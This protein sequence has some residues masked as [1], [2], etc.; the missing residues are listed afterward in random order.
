MKIAIVGAGVSGLTAAYILSREHTVTLYESQERLGGHAHTVKVPGG[1]GDYWVDTGFLVYN[2]NTYP[3]FIELMR[4]LDIPTKPTV[5]SFSYRN[6]STGLEWKGSNLNTVFGQRR[7]ILRPRF[8]RMVL[9]ILAFNR[10][11]RETLAGPADSGETL[12]QLLAKKGWSQ[13]FRDWYLRPMGASIWSANPEKFTNMP[14]RSFAEFFSRHGLLQVK[15]QPKWRTIDGGSRLYVE[16]ILDVLRERSVAVVH[17]AVTS[18]ARN[19]TVRVAT[20]SGTET[21]DHVVMACHSNEA[22]A[23]LSD[24]TPAEKEILGAIAYQDN[25]V[26]LH[27]DESLLPRLRRTWAAWNYQ[28]DPAVS[29]RATLTYNISTLQSIDAPRQ[30]LVS[31]NSQHAIDPEKVLRRFTYA[32]PVLDDI[33]VAAQSRQSELHTELTSFCGAYLGFGFHEDGARS[34][35][36]VCERFGLHL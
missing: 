8:W 1:D 32:H 17:E 24:P 9:D 10:H 28:D 7:N 25:E 18:V 26:T 35:V 22:L 21:F 5:M 13:E 19:E 14:A 36:Q 34:A 30:F 4:Q 2:E 20:V 29:D 15:N 33:T 6:L 23:L 12:A 11:L 16:K 31:L 27:T 3:Y